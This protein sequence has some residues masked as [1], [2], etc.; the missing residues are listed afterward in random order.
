MGGKI[1]EALDVGIIFSGKFSIGG[2]QAKFSPIS[3]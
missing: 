3:A 1:F 2:G